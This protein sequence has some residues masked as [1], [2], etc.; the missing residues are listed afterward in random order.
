VNKKDYARRVQTLRYDETLVRVIGGIQDDAS[1]IFMNPSSSEN[2]ILEAHAKI[3][4]M[5]IL[6]NAF[7]AI[8]ADALIDEDRES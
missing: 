4:A 3:R 8:E 2:E 5:G 7:D 6:G 1:A